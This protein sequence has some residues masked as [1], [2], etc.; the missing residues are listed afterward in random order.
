MMIC[1]DW[2][3]PETARSLALAGADIICHPANL[4]L[5]YCQD[6]MI[7][8]CVEN[9]VF[10]VTANRTGSESRAGATLRFT[11]LSEIVA[12]DGGVLA[13]AGVE[14]EEVIVRE[15]D[16]FEARDKAVTPQNDVLGDRRPD[17][18]R[19]G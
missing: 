9:R 7:T 17:L 2:I 18:Y 15:I 10:A 13:R 19:L 1:F 6:A 12:P 3:F 14:A 4:V 5:S 16:P 8:R 11:G